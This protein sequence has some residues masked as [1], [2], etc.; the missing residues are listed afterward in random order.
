M[1][2]IVGVCSSD[3]DC[4]EVH[5]YGG[6]KS[7]KC[8]HQYLCDPKSKRVAADYKAPAPQKP[9]APIDLAVLPKHELAG[10]GY[11]S[12]PRGQLCLPLSLCVG[13]LG[14]GA[15][16]V[17]S[18][19][20]GATCPEKSTCIRRFRCVDPKVHKPTREGKPVTAAPSQPGQLPEPVRSRPR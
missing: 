15:P 5:G 4:P 11:E 13:E 19:E 14:K 7:Q 16:V 17:G 9:P 12:C 1:S 6:P 8:Y 3:A 10:C 20:H 2:R 18:C